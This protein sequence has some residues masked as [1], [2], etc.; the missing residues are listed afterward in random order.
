MILK[1]KKTDLLKHSVYF[2]KLD[3]MIPGVHWKLTKMTMLSYL[4]KL[5]NVW[6]KNFLHMV[7]TSM[8][9]ESHVYFHS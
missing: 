8:F 5:A 9:K 6:M 1:L 3:Q 2:H 4:A 7:V